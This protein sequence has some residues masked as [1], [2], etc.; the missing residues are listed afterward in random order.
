[1]TARLALY[2]PRDLVGVR[3]YRHCQR[4]RD[5]RPLAAKVGAAEQKAAVWIEPQG[6]VRPLARRDEG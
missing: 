3:F 5:R 6:D 1:L 2:Q 4:W